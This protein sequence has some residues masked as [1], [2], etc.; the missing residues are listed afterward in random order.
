MQ[1]MRM[2]IMHT[3][4]VKS[5]I[6]IKKGSSTVNGIIDNVKYGMCCSESQRSSSLGHYM[7]QCTSHRSLHVIHL[8]AQQKESS[9]I[10]Y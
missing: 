5:I 10:C 4:P 7:S 6:R 1:L 3:I 8:C 2:S 9:S